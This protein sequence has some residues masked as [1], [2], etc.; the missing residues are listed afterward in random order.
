MNLMWIRIFLFSILILILFTGNA[1][2]EERILLTYKSSYLIKNMDITK[3][4]KN[5]LLHFDIPVDIVK[6]NELTKTLLYKYKYIIIPVTDMLP[7]VIEKELPH[8]KNSKICIIGKA[9]NLKPIL[10]K[11]EKKGF[12]NIKYEG[13]R[14]FVSPNK[15]IY[16]YKIINK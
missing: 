10:Y 14:Y 4:I 3:M 13:K 16:E 5:F 12:L 7:K 8:L 2:T 9:K 1:Y 15:L 11:D 6:F